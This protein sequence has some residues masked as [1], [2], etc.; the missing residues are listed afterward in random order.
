MRHEVAQRTHMA[1][2]TRSPT[3]FSHQLAGHPGSG[4]HPDAGLAEVD[5][6]IRVTAKKRLHQLEQAVDKAALKAQKHVAKEIDVSPKDVDKA[7]R[8]AATEVS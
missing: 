4:D 3:S 7:V 8:K 5:P 2:S 1:P 6:G